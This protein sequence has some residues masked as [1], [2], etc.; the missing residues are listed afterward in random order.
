[1][2]TRIVQALDLLAD[3]WAWTAELVED[4]LPALVFAVALVAFLV[5]VWR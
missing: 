5:A 3:A 2:A 1:M 4:L